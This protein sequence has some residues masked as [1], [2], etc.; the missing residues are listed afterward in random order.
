MRR[1]VSG[2]FSAPKVEGPFFIVKVED[3]ERGNPRIGKRCHATG[4]DKDEE[5]TIRWA[6]RE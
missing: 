6:K 2:F 5:E 1:R 4:Y 3:L